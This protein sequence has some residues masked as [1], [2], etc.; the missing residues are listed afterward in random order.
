MKKL[1]LTL[2]L[3]LL[4]M[5]LLVSSCTNSSTFKYKVKVITTGVSMIVESQEPTA[6]TGSYIVGDTVTISVINKK[7]VPT[8]TK[9]VITL[10]L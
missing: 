7:I 6:I 9:A 10:R 1:L 2:L 5:T 4:S 8:R 3:P